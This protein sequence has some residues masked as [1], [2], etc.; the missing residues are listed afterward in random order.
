MCFPS[1]TIQI[2][3]PPP[4]PDIEALLAEQPELPE[5][6]IESPVAPEV[7]TQLDAMGSEIRQRGMAAL[8]I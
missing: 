8:R 2:P 7:R 3:P 5:A 6:Q 1:T 4:M